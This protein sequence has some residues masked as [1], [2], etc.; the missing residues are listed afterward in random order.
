[1]TADNALA[2]FAWTHPLEHRETALGFASRLAALNGRRLHDMLDE[3][4]V[5][6][7]EV[8]DGLPS[9][10]GAVALLG[11]ADAAT[12]RRYTPTRTPNTRFVEV[13]GQLV[14][15]SS[16]NSMERRFCPACVQEDL[17]RFGGP[18]NARPWLR[19]E[20]TIGLY[21]SCEQ[22]G[23]LLQPLRDDTKQFGPFDYCERIADYVPDLQRLVDGAVRA[24]VSPYQEWLSDRLDGAEDGAPWL[25]VLPL[26][27]A[28]GLCQ[29]IGVSVLHPTRVQVTSLSASELAAAADAG[30]GIAR[31]GEAGLVSLLG[32]LHRAQLDTRGY[33]GPRDTYGYLYVFLLKTLS[34]PALDGVRGAVRRFALETMP[35]D[36]G[37]DLLGEPVPIR[38]LHT[39]QTAAVEAGTHNVTMRRLFEERGFAPGQ[40]IPSLRDGRVVSGDPALFQLV[41]DLKTA[42]RTPDV[43][44]E[45]G[46]TRLHL[47]SV[48]DRGHLPKLTAS[49]TDRTRHRFARSAVARLMDRFFEGAVDV[50][51]PSGRRLP[52]LDARKASLLDIAVVH[53]LILDG[54][55]TWKGRIAGRKDYEALVVDADE[56]IELG[57]TAPRIEGMSGAQTD[58]FL[59]GIDK[60][61]IGKLVEQGLLEAAEVPPALPQGCGYEVNRESA[62]AF[63]KRC[64]TVGEALRKTKLKKETFV[65][66][67][68]GAGIETVVDPD[69]VGAWIYNRKQVFEWLSNGPRLQAHLGGSVDEKGDGRT[70]SVPSTRRSAPKVAHGR[71]A[72]EG[73]GSGSPGVR[74]ARTAKR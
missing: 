61:V 68:R 60:P 38:R 43:G 35:L 41:D 50:D 12:L 74:A 7:T 11:G 47:A 45:T 22:H 66:L 30:Y 19:L 42:M 32:E 4:F 20:W 31:Q 26:Y 24:E 46:L 73:S 25:R 63:M 39:I 13:G 57:R 9:A 72:S 16:V 48:I 54:R 58:A 49:D 53:D 1:M 67:A 64:A 5:R 52:I 6:H 14:L 69:L 65:A 2:R 18:K 37:T 8:T 10:V 56:L 34:D 62:D 23:I 40:D 21:R 27:A 29:A 51:G 44:R 55:L 71:I 17:S 59:R 3:M 36:P 33:W 70:A 15:R 28:A